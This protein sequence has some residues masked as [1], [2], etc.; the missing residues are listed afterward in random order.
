MEIYG[1]SALVVSQLEAR[2]KNG[3]DKIELQLLNELFDENGYCQ[4]AEDV[5]DLA[6]ISKYEICAVHAPLI[7]EGDVNLEYMTIGEPKKALEEC[8][9]I[10]QYMA[11]VRKRK[12]IL[13]VHA[14]QSPKELIKMGVWSPLVVTLG[15]LLD[16]YP[17]VD[18]AIE[19]IIPERGI[20]RSDIAFCNNFKFDNAEMARQLNA[21]L[22]T[23]RIGTV[24]DTCHIIMTQNILKAIFDYINDPLYPMEDVSMKKFFEMNADVCKLIHLAGVQG[25][26]ISSEHHGVPLLTFMP[27]RLKILEEVLDLYFKFGYKCPITL[28]VCESDLNNPTNYMLAKQS[29]LRTLKGRS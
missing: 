27:E 14:G 4:K 3:F 15:L 25:N 23:D 18:I 12:I 22:E 1:K 13:I 7:K 17:D 2:I 10:A 11:N 19:N 6:A 26:G 8:F 28:E 5:Y 20:Q 21:T 24:I 29:L 16:K 9:K